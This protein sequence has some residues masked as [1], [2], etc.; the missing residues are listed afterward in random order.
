M[1]SFH[2]IIIE[3]AGDLHLHASQRSGSKAAIHALNSIIQNKIAM[4]F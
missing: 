2:R 1:V 3:S 4:Q